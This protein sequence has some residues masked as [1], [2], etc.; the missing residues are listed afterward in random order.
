[1]AVLTALNDQTDEALFAA[2]V[3]RLVHRLAALRDA[4][5][6][7]QMTALTEA[8]ARRLG[9]RLTEAQQASLRSLPEIGATRPSTSPATADVAALIA[10]VVCDD[11]ARRGEA[12]DALLALKGRAIRPLLLRLREE[13][14]AAEPDS[15]CQARLVQLLTTLAPELTGFDDAGDTAARLELVDR[16]IAKFDG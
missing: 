5:Q 8:A 3:E 10:V 12:T 2:A 16:W 1:M 9:E 13:L 14:A 6:D 4:G 7:E 11:E 15:A